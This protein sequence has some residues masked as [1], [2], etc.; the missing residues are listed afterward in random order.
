MLPNHSLYVSYLP[1]ATFAT[2]LS[3]TTSR[4][5]LKLTRRNGPIAR[6]EEDEDIEEER[7]KSAAS[8]NGR[9]SVGNLPYSSL[10]LNWPIEAGAVHCVEIIYDRVTNRS[11][12]FAFVTMGVEDAEKPIRMFDSSVKV[13]CLQQIFMA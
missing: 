11:R 3:P 6:G 8:A 1:P 12:G 4:L 13:M 7:K 9:L 5:L 10:L 2:P